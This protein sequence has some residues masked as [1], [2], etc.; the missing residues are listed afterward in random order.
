MQVLHSGLKTASKFT[1]FMY[2]RVKIFKCLY[3]GTCTYLNRPRVTCMYQN[4]PFLLSEHLTS[5]YGMCTYQNRPRNVHR[6]NMVCAAKDY[7]LFSLCSL[8][9]M[10][11]IGCFARIKTPYHK[12]RNESVHKGV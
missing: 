1:S 9:H 6:L 8:E 4:S 12:P 5:P 7:S 2:K 10:N 11:L 3:L